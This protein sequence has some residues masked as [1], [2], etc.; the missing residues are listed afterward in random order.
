VVHQLVEGER[1]AAVCAALEPYP[2][3]RFTSEM[4]ARRVLGAVDRHGVLDLVAGIPGAH[5]GALG[6]VEPVD[7]D[8]ERVEVL[9]EFLASHRW[10]A[11]T[12]GALCRQLLGV[13]DAWWLRRRWSEV[14]LGWLGDGDR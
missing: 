5:P 12:L 4:L 14:E 11:I 7:R 8:D 6:Q 1:V 9:V 13:L 2:W 3:Q 10:R